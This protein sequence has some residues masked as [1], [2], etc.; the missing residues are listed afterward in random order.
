ML[1]QAVLQP[2]FQ[3]WQGKLLW[4]RWCH[5]S[6]FDARCWIL[7][8]GA[9]GRPGG[10]VQ[11]GR[12]EEGSGWGAHVYLWRIHVDVWQNQYNTVKFKKKMLAIK[13]KKKK[14]LQPTVLET[15]IGSLHQEELLGKGMASHSRIFA[16]R[17][18]WIEEPG[19]L[20]SMGW[21]RVRHH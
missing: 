8:A 10:M 19:R 6:R 12:R 7:G 2:R 1:C 21:Q 17:I 16:W 11:A 20:Q 14:N 4:L 3:Q 5:Q 9:L 15:R 18:P 13:K